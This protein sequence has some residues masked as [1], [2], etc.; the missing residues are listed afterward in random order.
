MQEIAVGVGM[1]ADTAKGDIATPKAPLKPT[2]EGSTV[3]P[4]QLEEVAHD[5][6]PVKRCELE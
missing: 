4:L 6:G 1:G 5:D 3:R 2:L